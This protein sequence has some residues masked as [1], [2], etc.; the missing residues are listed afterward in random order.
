MF[1]KVLIAEDHEMTNISVQKALK[2]LGVEV[3]KY[4]HYCDHALNWI[5]NALRDKDP[6]DLII[7]DI[8]FEDDE[9]PQQIK[10]GLSLIKAIK[11]VQPDIKVILFTAKDRNSK[12]SEM[13]KLN[14]IDGM[15]R[16]SRRDGQYLQEALVAVNNNKSYQSP[17]VKKVIQERNSHE[18]TSF[19]LHIIRLLYEGISQKDMPLYLQQREVI[20]SSLS[21]IEKRLNIMKDVLN[22]TKNEQLVAHCKEIGI[23]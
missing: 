4:V 12:I 17:D 21:S 1:K 10:D 9:S 6:Y 14:Q 8:E 18:F 22:F 5:N 20:P 11:H 15:V 19:D 23:I 16:K 7:T 3:V 2:A 13:F